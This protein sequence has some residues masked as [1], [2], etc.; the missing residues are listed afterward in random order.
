MVSWD[1]FAE[2]KYITYSWHKNKSILCDVT[3]MCSGITAQQCL[4]VI[5]TAQQQ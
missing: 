2:K 4:V 1:L 3:G 5:E